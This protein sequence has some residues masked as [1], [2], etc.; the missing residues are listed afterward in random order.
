MAEQST[1]PKARAEDLREQLRKHNYH[2]YQ[3]NKPL[4]SDAEYDRLFN[5]L[6]ELEGEHPDL[7]TQDSPTQR[8]GGQVSDGFER[9]PHPAPILSLG[10]AH[11]ADDLRAWFERI[12]NLDDRVEAAE[13]TVEPKFDGLTVVLHYQ[14]G[15]FTL[16]A[17]R[18]N[19]EVGEDITANLRTVRTLPLRIPVGQ[20]DAEPPARLIVRGE[21]IIYT[22]DFERM[23][24]DLAARGERTYVNPRNTASGALRQLDP[25]LT[26]DRPIRLLCYAVVDAD[27]SIPNSQSARLSLLQE[28]GFPVSEEVVRCASLEEAIEAALALEER[29]HQLAYEVDGAVIKID[30]QALA[31]DLGVVGKDPRGAIAYKFAAEEVSTDLLEIKVNVGRTGVIT[32]YAVL[33]PVEVSGVTVQQATL[34]NFDFIE[35]KDI[36]VGD[37]VLI[38]RAGEVIPYVIGPLV[39]A[40]DGDEKR[41]RRPKRCPS[42]GEPLEQSEGEVA[43]YC[44][45][46]ACPAQLVRN[47]EH[48]AARSAMDIEGLGIKVAEQVVEADLVHDVAD[49]YRLSKEDLLQLEGFAETKAE[50]LIGAIDEARSRPLDRLLVAIGMR[51]VGDVAAGDLAAAFGDLDRLAAADMDSL[52]AIDGI[53]P[54]LA[55][56]IV[57]W[58]ELPRNQQLLKKLRAA[59]VWPTVELSAEPQARQSLTEKTFVL[60]GSLPT[61]TRGE[62]KDWIERRGGKV[63]S[64]VSG[65]TDYLVVGEDPGSKLLRARELEIQELTEEELLQLADQGDTDP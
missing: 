62:A 58:F 42:C 38:K 46:A 40:R 43:V 61:M 57:D 52:Q 10:N 44:V 17:T 24:R 4:V 30:D 45:N 23:N 36:R 41:Y 14:D 12:R 47:V 49:I 6:R 54:N 8:V 35:E 1:N 28:L 31:S 39:E 29:R 16:G 5:E 3:L 32:P 64:S 20:A 22:E 21:A 56:A 65:R 9:V 2:Y 33:A 63:T 48:F 15:V 19:G 13:F 27:G 25:S 50:N 53:G 11:S 60:T 26:A 55:A 18:G 59:D 34:H 51:G 7:R 37:R